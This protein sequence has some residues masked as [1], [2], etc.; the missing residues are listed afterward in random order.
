MPTKKCTRPSKAWRVIFNV[1]CKKKTNHY[2]LV[3]DF[4]DTWQVLFGK[5]WADFLSI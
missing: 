5:Y 4:A 1:G 2:K 3:T